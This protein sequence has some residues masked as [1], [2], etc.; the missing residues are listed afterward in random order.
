[1]ALRPRNQMRYRSERAM[2][3][4]RIAITPATSAVRWRT[5]SFGTKKRSS[6]NTLNVD[7]A[8]TIAIAPICRTRDSARRIGLLDQLPDRPR[9]A[10][11]HDVV[12]LRVRMDLVTLQRSIVLDPVQKVGDQQASFIFRDLLIHLFVVR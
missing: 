4:W 8:R 9:H 10:I 5:R 3:M 11:G 12:A 2:V 1:M 7:A 6:S